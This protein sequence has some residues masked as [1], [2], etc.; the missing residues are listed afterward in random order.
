MARK[1]KALSAGPQLRAWV[2]EV[3]PA[4]IEALLRHRQD[5]LRIITSGSE[6]S[7][8]G[9]VAIR[10]LDTVEVNP[11]RSG[12]LVFP[13]QSV[14]QLDSA[15]RGYY[16]SLASG[17]LKLGD[18]IRVAASGQTAK[19]AEI[20]TTDGLLEQAL[21]GQGVT[22]KLDR[23]LDAARGDVFSTIQDPHQMTDQFEATLV[24]LSKEAGLVGRS[25]DIQL[26]TQEAAASITSLKHRINVN[27]KAHE[28]AKKLEL[29]DVS[30]CHLATSK[31]LV[32]DSY[33]N[34]RALGGFI[35]LDRFTHATVAAGTISFGL[36]RAQ[37]V[38]KQA[39]S[40]TLQD[41]EKL[42]GHKGKVI[43]F[44]GLSGSGKSFVANALEVELHA[45]GRRTYLLDGD[46]VRQ[47]LNK[48]LGFTE[49]DRVENIRRIAEVAKLMMDAGL[50]VMTAFISPFH[51]EREMARELI[52]AQNFIEVFVNT[53]LEVCEQRDVKGLYKKA[54]AGAIPN[55]TGISSPYE[56]PLHPDLE[57]TSDAQAT[58]EHLATLIEKLA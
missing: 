10:G 34:S 43:W 52:G 31:P 30:V 7:V 1:P 38:H 11:Q 14:V 54:R 4:S 21:V 3:P 18:E 50:I 44:T 36:H 39:L 32:F 26:T 40:I 2:Q 12:K 8:R 48:D 22:L 13:V 49:A 58:K 25:Y 51:R 41:R 19:V 53:P 29:D 17:L 45:Q 28:A 56:E 42:N 33:Q 55:F 16:G 6:S 57:I 46:N 20:V 35:L 15:R 27:T 37:N 47:G 9:P 24:W 5:L 23:D